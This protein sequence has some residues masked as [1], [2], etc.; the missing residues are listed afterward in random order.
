MSD[1]ELRLADELGVVATG[2]P[3]PYVDAAGLARAGRLERVRRRSVASGL[4]AAAVAVVAVLAVTGAL[5][6]E[7]RAVDPAQ[8]PSVDHLARPLELAWWTGVDDQ[9]NPG[10]GALH[11]GGAVIPVEATRVVQARGRTFVAHDESG[12]EL[13]STVGDGALVPLAAVPLTGPP[14]VRGDG[15]AAWVEDHGTDGYALVE[16]MDGSGAGTSLPPGEPPVTVGLMNDGFVLLTVGDELV[17][18]YP[19]DGE[20]VPAVDVPRGMRFGLV[21]AWSGGLST[22]RDGRVGVAFVDQ[23]NRFVPAWET[24]GDGTGRWS[25]DGTQYAEATDAGIRVAT[26]V[27]AVVI[28][29]EA[30]R[31]QVVGWESATEVVVAQWIEADQAVTDVWRCDVGELRCAAVADAPNGRV[32]LPGL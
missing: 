32:L 13:W 24:E 8:A 18:S 22:Y 7:D 10:A 6:G 25:P 19:Q 4:V 15:S 9:T 20:L 27:G 3:T 14:V 1:L 28:P 17:T 12:V 23:D 29:L 31:R 30:D 26:E 2:L 11:V 5:A 21:E 16:E